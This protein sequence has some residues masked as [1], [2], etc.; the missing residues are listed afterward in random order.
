MLRKMPFLLVPLVLLCPGIG[1]GGLSD[2][3]NYDGCIVDSMRGVSSD[4][5][6]RAIIESCRK[7][8]PTSQTA[9]A[10]PPAAAAAPA[11]KAAPPAAVGAATQ[12]LP[13]ATPVPPA[14]VETAGARDLTADELARLRVKANV[15][16]S[17]YRVTIDNGNPHL[18]L[19]EVT[20]AVW[21]D[22][23]SGAGRKEYSEAVQVA[24]QTTAKVKYTVHYRG[25]ESSWRWGVAAA[26]G[27]E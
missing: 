9:A 25:D 23:D 22:S 3:S 13:A 4:V 10:P 15:F 2:V 8:F 18:T 14:P 20:I 1:Y 12:A 17:S 26:R 16:G 27:V 24:P 19:T 21:D 5:A 7:L 11:G 6:A